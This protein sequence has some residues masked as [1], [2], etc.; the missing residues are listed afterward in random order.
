[1]DLNISSAFGTLPLWDSD[2][3]IVSNI[4]GMTAAAVNV[5]S[6]TVYSMDG[7]RITNMQTQ[8]RE[9]IIDLTIKPDVSVEA[10]KEHVFKHIK[11]KQPAT[12]LLRYDL[13]GAEQSK[14]ITGRISNI[15]MPRFTNNV[16][17]Q[18]TLYCAQPY[19]ED[20][21]YIVKYISDILNLHRFEIT[22]S[23]PLPM[24]V[25]D[26][27]RTR[28]FL[29]EGDAAVGMIVT[30]TAQGD[31]VNPA[32]YNNLTG[33]YIGIDDTLSVGDEI[34]INT[35]RGQ[36]SITKNGVNVLSKLRAGSTWMQLDVGEN[37]F[38][39]DADSGASDMYFTLIFKQAYV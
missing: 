9:I 20:A 28:S 38:L 11:P 2:Y 1:M 22:W 12:L 10:A 13:S 17:M 3:F 5:S 6:N 15:S 24:G 31:V 21:E 29:N 39:I 34:V 35:I 33:E 23:E 25:Y 8:P 36:K 19:W 14:A 27:T 7:D 30:I 18:I 37:T 32:L 4:D 26:M 16:I